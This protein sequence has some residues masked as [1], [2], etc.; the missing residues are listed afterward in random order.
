MGRRKRIQIQV[1][2]EQLELALNEMQERYGELPNPL[3]EPKRFQYY[4]NMYKYEKT[5]ELP[6]KTE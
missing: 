1:T 5:R 4:V 6:C 2:D 3:H